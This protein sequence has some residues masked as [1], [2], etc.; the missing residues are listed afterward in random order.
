MFAA[1]EDAIPS[2]MSKFDLLRGEEAYKQHWRAQAKPHVSNTVS[3]LGNDPFFQL[4]GKL[5][6]A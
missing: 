5:R 1:M 3:K 6:P 4:R 2:G